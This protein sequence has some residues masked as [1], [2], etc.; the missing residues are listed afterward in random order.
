MALRNGKMTF[1]HSEPVDC[2]C[3]PL[4]INGLVGWGFDKLVP[5]WITEK[6]LF[7]RMN[8]TVFDRVVGWAGWALRH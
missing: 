5:T 2:P 8:M 4:S 7:P 1:Q 3:H 6:A